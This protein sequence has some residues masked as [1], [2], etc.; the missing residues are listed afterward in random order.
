MLSTSG[1]AGLDAPA[2][3]ATCSRSSS[4]TRSGSRTNS[5]RRLPARA[6][7]R[8]RHRLAYKGPAPDF[9][10]ARREAARTSAAFREAQRDE[11]GRGY[12]DPGVARAKKDGVRTLGQFIRYD[13]MVMHGH[14][15]RR[16]RRDDVSQRRPAGAVTRSA[17][18][19]GVR[20]RSY[21]WSA[22]GP[23]RGG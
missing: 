2:N 14:A 16:R 8:E 18:R 10:A 7:R 4:R 19:R 17:D 15:R 1:A 20:P 12:F 22:R 13:A 21:P 9:P 11:R 3:R 23:G 6:V 5:P